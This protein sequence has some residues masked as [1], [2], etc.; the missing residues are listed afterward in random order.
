MLRA[1]YTNEPTSDFSDPAARDAMLAAL[2]KVGGELGREYPLIIG[3][4][5]RETGQ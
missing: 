4:E 2:E 1:A 3:G 5:R